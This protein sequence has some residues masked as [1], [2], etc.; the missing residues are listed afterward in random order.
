MIT[1]RVGQQCSALQAVFAQQNVTT[2]CYITAFTPFVRLLTK[3]ENEAR[4]AQLLA[5]LAS[6][7]PVFENVGVD[8]TGEWEGVASYLA[9]GASEDAS[10][11]LADV[12]EQNAVVF[13]DET[14]TVSL[15]FTR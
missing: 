12:W 5:E 10:L 7:Y 3:Q 4:N 2:A 8:L 11:A 15:L 13:V 6:L 1:L 14:F 9:L